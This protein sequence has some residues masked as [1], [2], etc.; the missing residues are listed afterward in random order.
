VLVN[1]VINPYP[2]DGK[3]N[4]E[5]GSIPAQVQTSE[6][7]FGV[8]MSKMPRAPSQPAGKADALRGRRVMSTSPKL[9]CY[10]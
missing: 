2:V 3:V 9:L 7:K 6:L 4:M 10:W 5:L 8:W 1:E